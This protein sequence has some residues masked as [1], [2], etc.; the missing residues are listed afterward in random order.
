MTHAEILALEA[1]YRAART[2][3][4]EMAVAFPCEGVSAAALIASVQEMESAMLLW[5]NAKQR[6]G[7]GKVV[8]FPVKKT[9]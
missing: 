6:E 2:V 5:D 8:A 1:G 9:A 3:F 7:Y 4:L